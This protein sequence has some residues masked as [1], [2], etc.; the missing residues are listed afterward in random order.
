MHPIEHLRYVARASGADHRLLVQETAA[1]IGSFGFDPSGL[2]TACKRIL[3]RHPTVGPLWWLAAHVLT[4]ADPDEAAWRCVEQISDDPTALELAHALPDEATV[5]VV[6]WPAVT[7]EALARRGDCRVLVV[8]ALDEGSGLVR[9]LRRSDV[10]AIQVPV[11]G[12][13]AAAA[14]SDVV[15][16]EASA[17]GP[18]GFVTIQGARAA[19]CVAWCQ[20]RPVWVVGGVGR[21]LPDAL[22]SALASR[23]L[24]EGDPWELDDEIV[25]LELATRVAGPFGVLEP[26]EALAHTDTP[27]AAELLKT[28]PF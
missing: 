10:E 16:L 20:E 27:L 7:G 9:R 23:V 13:G 26:A 2:V 25:P 14:L 24:A 17:I 4:A 15:V 21:L 5:C 11:S 19:A 1:A 3:E 12:L 6:G 18:G 28:V 22:F 8:D